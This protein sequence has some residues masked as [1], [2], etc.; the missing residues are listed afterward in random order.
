MTGR[1]TGRA[2]AHGPSWKRWGSTGLL[3]VLAAGIAAAVL[4]ALAGR[5][6]MSWAR[7]RAHPVVVRVAVSGEIEPAIQRLGRF[8]NSEH[9]LV[10]GR[11]AQVRVR[12]AT[13]AGVTA[14]LARGAGSGVDAWIPD[15]TLWLDIARS[16]AAA[17]RLIHP[18][19]LIVARSPLMSAISRRDAAGMRAFG[20]PVS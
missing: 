12:A 10:R 8:F 14:A 11:C 4:T 2:R 16:S 1:H 9:Q 6:V 7:C 3:L 20:P 18:D 13:P 17:A 19:G 5:D 15:S